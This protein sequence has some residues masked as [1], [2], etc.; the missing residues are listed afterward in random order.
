MSNATIAAVPAGERSAG[1]RT[2]A[3]P[4]RFPRTT[5]HAMGETAIGKRPDDRQ[6]VLGGPLRQTLNAVKSDRAKPVSDA[7]WFLGPGV[8]A[9]EEVLTDPERTL[10]DQPAP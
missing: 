8:P 5:R 2:D 4:G 9:A 7:T 1:F 10:T 3:R 6:Q